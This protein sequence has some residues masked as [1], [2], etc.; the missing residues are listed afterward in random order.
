[1]PPHNWKT[2]SSTL[3]PQTSTISWKWTL[4]SLKKSSFLLVDIYSGRLWALSCGVRSKPDQTTVDSSCVLRYAQCLHHTP[5]LARWLEHTSLLHRF[6]IAPCLI[7]TPPLLAWFIH[8][9][10]LHNLFCAPCL[11]HAWLALCILRCSIVW[12]L[13]HAYCTLLHFEHYLCTHQQSIHVFSSSWSPSSS[14]DLLPMKTL[15][16]VSKNLYVAD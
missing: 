5:R 12:P 4:A 3:L 9:S 7:L 1:M 14:I 8:P 15:V 16:S 2:P 13:P 10:Q 6:I 11:Q